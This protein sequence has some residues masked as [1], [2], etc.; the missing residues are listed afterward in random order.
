MLPKQPIIFVQFS[1]IEKLLNE[2]NKP[3]IEFE[4]ELMRTNIVFLYTL[5]QKSTIYIDLDESEIFSIVVNEPKADYGNELRLFFNRICYNNK[6]KSCKIQLDLLLSS[7]KSS[8][9]EFNEIPTFLL[10][11]VDELRAR[12][13][14]EETGIICIPSSLKFHENLSKVLV[15]EIKKDEFNFVEFTSFLCKA[16]NIII[17]DPYIEKEEGQKFI[18][19][20]IQNL[21][22]NKKKYEIPI[23]IL[24]LIQDK[25]NYSK[26]DDAERFRL[27]Y[28]NLIQTISE[29]TENNENYLIVK[30]FLKSEKMHDRHIYSESFWISCGHSF[31]MKYNVS[32][33]WIYRPIGIYFTQYEKRIKSSTEFIKKQQLNTKNRLIV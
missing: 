14:N 21:I 6:L 19:K 17:E 29:L 32:T 26:K 5:F 8:S 12:E 27:D 28:N 2:L 31:K 10:L 9:S 16:K 23:N 15:R 30:R 11:D 25:S 24:I 1:F 4:D 18:E 20:L 33:E 22:D 3:L 13:I 7:N